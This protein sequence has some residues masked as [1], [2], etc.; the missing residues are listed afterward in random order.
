MIRAG[1]PLEII[2]GIGPGAEL[3]F[4]YCVERRVGPLDISYDGEVDVL[5]ISMGH[6]RATHAEEERDGLLIEK[7]ATTGEIVGV[8]VLDYEQKFRRLRDLSW[9]I[10]LPLAKPMTHF[11]IERMPAAGD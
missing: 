11:L 4:L 2:P 3:G 9:L 6:P 10:H 5:Y 1:L 7:D 8:T